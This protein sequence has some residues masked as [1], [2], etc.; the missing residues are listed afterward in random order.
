MRNRLLIIFLVIGLGLTELLAQNAQPTSGGVASGGGGTMSYTVGQLV[1]TTNT[2]SGGTISQGVQQSY[3]I[4]IITDTNEGKQITLSVSV[5]PNP[6]S[7]YL[8]LHFQNSDIK[9]LSYQLIDINGKTLEN[10]SITGSETSINMNKLVRATYFLKVTNGNTDI[11][12]FKI[13]KN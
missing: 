2:G 3:E 7:D 9:E 1:Y 4:W 10:K 12:T 5:F 8:I 6:T 11:K 13:I